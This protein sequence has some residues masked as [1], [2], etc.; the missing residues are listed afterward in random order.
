[1]TAPAP[2]APTAPVAQ[3]QAQPRPAPVAPPVRTAL[4]VQPASTG[5]LLGVGAGSLP[6]PVPFNR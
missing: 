5:S 2:R 1:A 3:A 4:H 6:P